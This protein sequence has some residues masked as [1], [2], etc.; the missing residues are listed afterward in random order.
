MSYLERSLLPN[1]HIVRRGRLPQSDWLG[2][3][4]PAVVA[5]WFPALWLIV[6]LIVLGTFIRRWTIEIA[7]QRLIYKHGW[8]ARK[9]EEVDLRRIAEIN[10]EQ[11]PMGR[12][13][14]FGKVLCRGVGNG[15]IKLP[16]IDNPMDFRRALQEAQVKL[17][18]AQ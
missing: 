9:T 2:L 14:G 6:A 13:F 12:I 15:G 10:L 11:G 1:E 18:S 17:A 7:N 3:V 5:L 16:P 8:I 4:L